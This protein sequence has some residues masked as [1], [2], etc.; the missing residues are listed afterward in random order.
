MYSCQQLC[1]IL[2]LAVYSWPL[3]QH[4]KKQSQ[5]GFQ[6]LACS[7]AFDHTHG[8][9]EHLQFHANNKDYV[10]EQVNLE[11]KWDVHIFNYS[12]S[13]GLAYVY[14]ICQTF[15]LIFLKRDTYPLTLCTTLCWIIDDFTFMFTRDSCIWCYNILLNY[16]EKPERKAHP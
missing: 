10:I 11:L 8:P 2:S 4:S 16:W 12:G 14:C 9:H 6:P 15:F 1:M 13:G 3:K 7:A 5:L